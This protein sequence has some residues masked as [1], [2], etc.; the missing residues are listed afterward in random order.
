MTDLSHKGSIIKTELGDI[1]SDDPVMS[2]IPG[3]AREEFYRV[4][5]TDHQVTKTDYFS[6][7][8]N[9]GTKHN[10]VE[11]FRQNLPE[12]KFSLSLNQRETTLAAL[13]TIENSPTMPLEIVNRRYGYTLSSGSGTVNPWTNVQSRGACF[14]VASKIMAAQSGLELVPGASATEG[15]KNLSNN[16]N[17][18]RVRTTVGELDH[19]LKNGGE[20]PDGTG[21]FY[22]AP[23][24]NYGHACVAVSTPNGKTSFVSDFN[25]GNKFYVYGGFPKSETVDLFIPRD[26][27]VKSTT[28]PPSGPSLSQPATTY[29]S[30]LV[31]PGGI[32]AIKESDRNSALYNK[33]EGHWDGLASYLE[34]QLPGMNLRDPNGKIVD[35]ETGISN[36]HKQF[37]IPR[38]KGEIVGRTTAAMIL[39]LV[40]QG[41]HSTVRAPK[42]VVPP[43][44]IAQIKGGLSIATR[45]T[46]VNPNPNVPSIAA[47]NTEDSSKKIVTGLQQ[48]VS[49]GEG[50]PWDTRESKSKSEHAPVVRQALLQ[51]LEKYHP[52][53]LLVKSYQD[54]VVQL[55]QSKSLYFGVE[56]LAVVKLLRAT[57]ASKGLS[58]GNGLGFTST[59]ASTLLGL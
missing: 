26:T 10:G 55:N 7:P 23:H 8:P 17:Y 31:G 57:G 21:V 2:R 54:R 5:K 51:Y 6:L 12:T 22:R 39:T 24:H 41:G 30:A 44:F 48:M 33:L 3:K 18:V 58:V 9:S 53:S 49:A 36:L 28:T 59:D 45:E 4:A 42:G 13:G 14:A 56:D 15:R 46:K 52:E 37:D 43:E 35:F 19:Y 38:N 29:Y 20:L 50:I 1:T 40:E 11:V 47:V 32:R 27:L 34:K 25:Q 16:P